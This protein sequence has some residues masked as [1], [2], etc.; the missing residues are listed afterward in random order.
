MAAPTPRLALTAD[1]DLD[2]STGR[3][4]VETDPVKNIVGKVRK[5]LL[6]AQAEWFLA[7]ADGVPW[8]Q[9]ILAK[10]NPDLRIV[11]TV[12]VTAILS[13]PEVGS[14]ENV[15]LV[16]DRPSRTCTFTAQLRTTQGAI[17][18]TQPLAIP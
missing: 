1:G 5:V 18:I 2:L 12:L 15:K 9:Q 16:F 8:I 10:K 7:A 3:L 6:L 4:V 13:V 14:V 17:P 11:Q